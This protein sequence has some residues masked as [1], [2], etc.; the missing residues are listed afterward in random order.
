LSLTTGTRPPVLG[1]PAFGSAGADG[2]KASSTNVVP[3]ITLEP[4]SVLP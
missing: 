1:E 3:T 2:D 4:T